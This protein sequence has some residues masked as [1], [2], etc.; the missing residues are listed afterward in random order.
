MFYKAYR[1]NNSLYKYVTQP[2]L[3]YLKLKLNDSQYILLPYNIGIKTFRKVNDEISQTIEGILTV[4]NLSNGK[5]VCNKKIRHEMK[6]DSPT[7][8]NVKITAMFIESLVSNF[9][10][11]IGK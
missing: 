2:E 6:I 9:K 1:K 11:S 5:I 3:D 10:T 8:T 4:F 7:D